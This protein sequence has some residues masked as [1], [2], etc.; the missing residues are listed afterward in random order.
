M[1][2]LLEMPKQTRKTG[3]PSAKRSI[4]CSALFASLLLTLA[5][6]LEPSL[7]GQG[8]TG[9]I[10]GTVTD[11]SGA[12]VPGATV[13]VR[14]VDTNAARITTTSD[15]G[16][17]TVTQLAP[18]AYSV[19]VDKTGFKTFEQNDIILEINQIAQINAQL[20]IGSAQE[21]V[22]VSGAPPVIQTEDSSVGL[23]VDSQT[24]LNTPLN[25]R[26]SLMGLIA[27]APGVQGAGAQDQLAVRG[28]T[29]SIGTGTRNSY[30]GFGSTLD[31]VTNQEVTLQRGEAEVPS[32]DAIAQFK[33]ISTGAPA[34]FNQPAQMIVVSKSGT[35]QL[36]GG[37]LEYNRSK[38][39]LGKGLLRGRAATATVRA[40]R[41]RRPISPVPSSS[42]NSTTVATGPS[43]S[44]PL[45]DFVCRS[46][47]MSTV[48]SR[49]S[50]S[51]AETSPHSS[52]MAVVQ[53]VVVAHVSTTRRPDSHFQE[54]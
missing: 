44:S 9:S 43:S 25:G 51:E 10:A 13:T 39:H 14:Q 6:G 35:N 11:S 28:V 20:G 24:I 50:P 31:G 30:G 1:K 26:L 8:I 18:G 37:V 2:T 34:E 49:P 33:V 41:I 53:L 22:V 46:P 16:S 19:K 48:S 52:S 47:P 17:Y 29:P 3:T 27:L 23:V 5:L 12:G 21:T 42:P 32:L 7:F 36:H 40:E 4:W 54:T 45:K 38:G 15:I